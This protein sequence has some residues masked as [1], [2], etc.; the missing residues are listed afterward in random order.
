MQQENDGADIRIIPL[1]AVPAL[2]PGTGEALRL[3]RQLTGATL[4]GAP[5]IGD[6]AVV[7]AQDTSHD[8]TVGYGT[9]G[10]LFSWPESIPWCADRA[11][12][13]KVT[14]PTNTSNSAR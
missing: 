3:V 9:E 6:K 7:P 11:A 10:G 2:R 14:P 5:P 1:G 12:W 13:S 4:I 8:G